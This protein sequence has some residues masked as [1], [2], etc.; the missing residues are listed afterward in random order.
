MIKKLGVF[1]QALTTQFIALGIIWAF[2]VG[3]SY[4]MLRW[5]FKQD[6]PWTKAVHWITGAMIVVLV[7]MGA[8]YVLPLSITAPISQVIIPRLVCAMALHSMLLAI[9][10]YMIHRYGEGIIPTRLVLSI[11]L[12]YTVSILGAIA[13]IK[14]Q[15]KFLIDVAEIVVDYLTKGAIAGLLFLEIFGGRCKEKSSDDASNGSSNSYS[16][17]W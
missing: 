13:L 10:R 4:V 14:I 16:G 12:V 7:G 6:I 3:V 9:D 5:C 11:I 15:N 17:R 8:L 2:L 1:A